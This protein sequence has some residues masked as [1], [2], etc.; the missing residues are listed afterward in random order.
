[1]VRDIGRIRGKEVINLNENEKYNDILSFLMTNQQ[2]KEDIEI[3]S[4]IEDISFEINN[5]NTVSVDNRKKL[6]LLSNSKKQEQKETQEKINT[7]SFSEVEQEEKIQK[8][9]KQLQEEQHRYEVATQEKKNLESLLK[10]MQ[11]QVKENAVSQNRIQCLSQNI[12]EKET[13]IR[14]LEFSLSKLDQTEKN[15]KILTEEKEKLHQEILV[16]QNQLSEYR[17]QE[18]KQTIDNIN[19]N[20]NELQ[21][22]LVSLEKTYQK[23]TLKLKEK[24]K[25]IEDY[26]K[27]L[28]ELRDEQDSLTCQKN[29]FL[30]KERNLQ[31][32]LDNIKKLQ[33]QSEE[34]L[35]TQQQELKE[36]DVYI[37]QQQEEIK[38]KRQDVL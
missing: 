29:Y 6:N 27:L 1:M 24:E 7:L 17:E 9:Q 23:E 20:Q 32:E 28:Q 4:V 36:K 15:N 31:K 21:E 18:K 3:M 30:T 26:T 10:N 5:T 8:L 12:E 35:K 25:Q 38:Q 22:K 11:L 14:E 16:Y 13:M 19:H 37:Q 2:T 34:L 33:E